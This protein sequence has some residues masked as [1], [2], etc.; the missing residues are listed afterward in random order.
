MNILMPQTEAIGPQSTRE[1]QPK[2]NLGDQLSAWTT[3]QPTNDVYINHYSGNRAT[4]RREILWCCT[5]RPSPPWDMIQIRLMYSAVGFEMEQN[6][7]PLAYSKCLYKGWT[8]NDRLS[9]GYLS[10][11][12]RSKS[13]LWKDLFF[14][15]TKSINISKYRLLRNVQHDPSVS[16]ATQQW[17]ELI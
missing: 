4:L 13:E 12:F 16:C 17:A 10:K 15:F 6:I 8:G 5:R 2:M 9:S 1:Y 14:L 11:L 3:F 7:F